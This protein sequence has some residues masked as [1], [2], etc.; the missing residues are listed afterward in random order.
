M[1][2]VLPYD[3]VRPRLGR[4]VFL[5]PTSTV[6][7]DVT[8]GDDS[9][10]WFG[11]VVRGDVGWIRIG[12]RTNVQDLCCLHVTSGVANLTVGD[13]VTVGHR[14][15]LHGCTVGDGCLIGIGS[16]V[17]D[18]ASIGAGAIIAAG[19]LV[20]PAMVVPP[21]TLVRGVPGRCVGPVRPEHA[22]LG[23]AGA[24]HYVEVA[25]RYRAELAAPQR[26]GPA[27][28]GDDGPASQR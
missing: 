13:E 19:A 3:G 1:A 21:R 23:L 18:G 22:E 16:V 10:I 5:A 25:S 8:I 24:H 27:G 11:T 17:L 20:P 6:V 26:G 2:L 14:V 9:S 12:A 4:R 7:G 15:V 28:G